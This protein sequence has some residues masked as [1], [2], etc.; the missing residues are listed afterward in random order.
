MKSDAIC[1]CSPMRKNLDLNLNFIGVFISCFKH[2]FLDVYNYIAIIH[3]LFF[4]VFY[5]HFK[6]IMRL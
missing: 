3:Y 1:E 4:N 6:I 2:V 5:N